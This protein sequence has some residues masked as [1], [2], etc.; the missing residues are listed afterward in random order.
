[1]KPKKCKVC[2]TEFVPKNDKG[3]YCSGKC[4]SMAYR[5]NMK[6]RIEKYHIENDAKRKLEDHIFNQNFEIKRLTEEINKGNKIIENLNMQIIDKSID[7]KNLTFLFEQQK[8][9]NS[10]LQKQNDELKKR[11]IIYKK[12][13]RN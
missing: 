3:M 6:V 1:M 7:Y 5:K 13:L 8:N 2:K 10:N 4:R 12:Q 11:V 9:E